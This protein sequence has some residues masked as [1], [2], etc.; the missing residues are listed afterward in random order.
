MNLTS[1]DINQVTPE[2]GTIATGKLD[3]SKLA[4]PLAELKNGKVLFKQKPLSFENLSET[5]Q[6]IVN[7]RNFIALQ[8]QK[9]L[10]IPDIHLP[11]IA[12]LVHESDKTAATLAKSLQALLIPPVLESSSQSSTTEISI[13]PSAVEHAI[14]GVATRVNYGII[15]DSDKNPSGLSVWRWEVKNIE[16]LPKSVRET[17]TQRSNERL[18]AKKQLRLMFEALSDDERNAF[19]GKND[20]YKDTGLRVASANTGNLD[21]VTRDEGSDIA[22]SGS[23]QPPRQK[24]STDP[25]AIAKEKERQEKKAIRAQ[26]EKKAAEANKKSAVVFAN[27]FKAGTSEKSHKRSS[28]L[29]TQSSSTGTK[30]VSDHDA[31]FKPFVV[32]KDVQ[33]APCNWFLAQR[34]H[35]NRKVSAERKT[36]IEID[37][38]GRQISTADIEHSEMDVDDE[39]LDVSSLSSRET[40][41]Y[42]LDLDT[43]CLRESTLTIKQQRRTTLQRSVRSL[44]HELNDAEV[45]GNHRSVR[46]LTAMLKDRSVIPAKVFIFAENNRPG[47]LGTWTKVS[48]TIGPRTPFARD[49]AA[50]NYEL[51]SDAEWEEEEIGDEVDSVDDTL[52]DDEI[53]S[54]ASDLVDWLVEGDEVEVEPLATK[55]GTIPLTSITGKRKTIDNREALIKRRRVVPLIPFQKGPAW[56]YELG[57]CTYEPFSCMRIQSFNDITFPLDPFTFT[58]ST[59]LPGKDV[60]CSSRDATFAV[61]AL[62]IAAE[63]SQQ[64]LLVKRKSTNQTMP[65]TCFPE[66]HVPLL[67]NKVA[68][69]NTSSF[70]VLL[71]TMFQDLKSF[72]IKKNA[73]EAKLREVVEK[74]K[75][76]KIWV[77]R[78]HIWMQHGLSKPV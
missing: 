42:H 38:D 61:P 14:K 46:K 32:K 28:S 33:M 53:S 62:P 71:D 6:E 78:D 56:E 52:D 44:M 64:G 7:F 36:V 66:M 9:I 11:L 49:L 24:K 13:A 20:K 51:D 12:K 17:A 23:R 8:G 37:D 27:F 57:T 30:P 54:V 18:V 60:Q 70:I 19:L 16:W 45:Q 41:Q 35:R 40:L 29:H 69:C 50:F 47:Y 48:S 59:V 68:A 55:E 3:K 72:G 77:V 26:K 74:D 5:M 76:K 63:A 39:E 75:S 31:T 1:S 21:S 10:E 15:I 22:E 67:L 43:P 4:S 34:Q 2:N 25:E 58:T 65:K 73:L